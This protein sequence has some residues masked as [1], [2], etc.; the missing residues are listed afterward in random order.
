MPGRVRLFEDGQ[1]RFKVHPGVVGARRKDVLEFLNFT[2]FR[3]LLHFPPGLV[4]VDE[5]LNQN[6]QILQELFGEATDIVISLVFVP[7]GGSRTLEIS[8]KAQAGAHDYGVLVWTPRGPAEAEGTS[9]PKII[10]DP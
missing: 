2:S 6:K 1:G 8:D 4:T 3:A 9:R 5:R 10:V 7:A